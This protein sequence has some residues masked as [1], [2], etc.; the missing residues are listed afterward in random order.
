MMRSALLA[1]TLCGSI[2]LLAGCSTVKNPGKDIAN[3]PAAS[4]PTPLPGDHYRYDDGYLE[5]V[6]RLTIEGVYWRLGN[7]SGSQVAPPDYTM[8]SAEW[9]TPEGVARL[10]TSSENANFW[11][12]IR[13]KK[14]SHQTQLAVNIN[15]AIR[16]YTEKWLCSV[17]GSEQLTLPA[18]TFNVHRIN[19]ARRSD[20]GYYGHAQTWFHAPAIGHWVRKL[21]AT[22]GSWRINAQRDLVSYRQVPRWL[23]LTGASQHEADFQHTLEITPT[24]TITQV[25]TSSDTKPERLFET[26][27]AIDQT[28]VSQDR[29]VCRKVSMSDNGG[30]SI[31]A[32]FCRFQNEWVLRAIRSSE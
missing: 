4:M 9:S 20:S 5:R 30:P 28:Y 8:P 3:L 31:D 12:I 22:Q 25:R 26:T 32:T 27:V 21:D 2:G 24:G 7:G 11:P 29:K 17:D 15:G 16:T 13:G 6:Q 14:N 10:T 23:G 1:W 19:C 18:G